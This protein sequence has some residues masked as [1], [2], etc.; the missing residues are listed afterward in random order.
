[1]FISTHPVR[2]EVHEIIAKYLK[3]KQLLEERIQPAELFEFFDDGTEE[4]KEL[5]RILDFSDGN[6]LSG[7]VAEKYFNDCINKLNLFSVDQKI[8]A[9]KKKID[10]E[11]TTEGRKAYALKLQ[12]LIQQREKLKSGAK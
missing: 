5:C 10:A 3:S 7:E 12:Q 8:N 1:M 2:V 6:A 4:Y 9:L 11:T